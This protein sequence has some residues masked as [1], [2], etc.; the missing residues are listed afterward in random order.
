MK[1]RRKKASKPAINS[2]PKSGNLSVPAVDPPSNTSKLDAV[3]EPTEIVEA[4]LGAG[5]GS[6]IDRLTYSDHMF[7]DVLSVALHAIAARKILDDPSLVEAARK[8]L[9]IWI[10]RHQRAPRPFV[11]WR[12]ILAGTPQKIAAVAVSLTEEAAQLRSSSPLGCLVTSKERAAVYALFGK[13]VPEAPHAEVLSIAVAMRS[14][15]VA[16]QVI[17]RAVDLSPEYE[18]FLDLMRMWR[19]EADP[20]ER[21]ATVAAI[22]ELIDDCAGVEVESPIIGQTV[23]T[24]ALG[25]FLDDWEREHGSF[26]AHELAKAGRDLSVARQ[27]GWQARQS[28]W[29]IL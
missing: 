18:G 4:E 27:S 20:N 29:Q 24:K 5:H 6:I 19:D 8:T 2:L 14:Q 12:H 23:A 15:G 28:G 16:D 21:E 11:E 1:P 10:S 7:H 22:E 25:D 17:V 26:T 3:D 13:S 9:E